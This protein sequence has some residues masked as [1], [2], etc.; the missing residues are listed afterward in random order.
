MRPAASTPPPSLRILEPLAGVFL[1]LHAVAVGAFR[2]G[3][4]TT[5]RAVI[6]AAVVVVGGSGCLGLLPRSPRWTSYVRAAAAFGFGLA[7]QAVDDPVSGFF[8]LWF[9]VIASLYPLVLPRA[10]ARVVVAAVPLGYFAL[11]PLAPADDG[12]PQVRL[13][14]CCVLGFIGLFALRAAHAYAEAVTARDESLALLE[15]YLDGVPVGLAF[16]DTS[17]RFRRLN[18]ALAEMNGLPV[19]AH[20]GRRVGE[21]VPEL[22]FTEAVLEQVLR[23]GRPVRDLEFSGSTPARPGVLRHWKASFHRVQA[24]E[25]VTG[26]G[27]VVEEVTQARA[28]AERMAWSASHDELTRLANRAL[29]VQ[30][31]AEQLRATPDGGHAAVLFCDVDRFKLV[32]DSLGHTA[33]DDLLRVVAARIVAAVRPQDT[34]A[35][36]GGDE[37]AVLCTGLREA[38]EAQAIAERVRAVV[39]AP[40]ELDTRTVTMSVSVGVCL[41]EPGGSDAS[42]LLRDADVAMY[43]AKDAGRDRTE[44]FD[45]RLRRRAQ[46]RLDV[47]HALRG[48]LDRDEVRLAYQPV[49]DLRPGHADLS[50]EALARWCRDGQDV[51]PSVFIPLAEDLGLI[52]DLGRRVLRRACADVADWR[53]AS[54]L[55]L[56]VAVNLSAR[57]LG[58]ADLADQVGEALAGS[59][60]SPSA[61]TLEITESVLVDDVDLSAARL[62]DLRALGARISI[63]DFGT[64]YSS[65]AYLRDLPVDVLKIDRSFVNRLPD[66]ESMVAV[67]VELAHT[68][69]AITVAEGVETLDQLD[70]LHRIGCDQVQGYLL[71]RPLPPDAV[72]AFLDGALASPGACRDLLAPAPGSAGPGVQRGSLAS[73][74]AS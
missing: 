51:P 35:R 45:A 17:L 40:I 70:V 55:D 15:T 63:D 73:P 25:Q 65:L 28:D 46:A 14:R 29:F 57:Q 50:V 11:I 12:P 7:L 74:A 58:Q 4:G 66:D 2:P 44:V 49:L 62:A 24:G 43:Q 33:G 20:L 8:L 37:F 59:G 32:N 71:S 5:M 64:G 56:R 47:E 42:D 22:R 23:T 26:V 6:A 19:A 1:A 54:G 60:L 10:A 67:I 38:G 31:L 61:L 13:L 72:P 48:A 3:A 9:F 69:G 53:C 39:R 27:V 16:W 36:F 68:L 30:R 18:A 21:V 41:A 52:H 34:V